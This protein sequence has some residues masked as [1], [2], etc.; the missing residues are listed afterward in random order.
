MYYNGDSAV[1]MD[2]LLTGIESGLHV[3]QKTSFSHDGS[4]PNLGLLLSSKIMIVDDEELNIEVV[5]EYLKIDGYENLVSTNDAR[6]AV[7]A[8]YHEKPDLVLLDLN[9][10]QVSG[11]DI[12][13]ELRS[14]QQLSGMPVIVLTANTD[15]ETKIRALKL[16]ATDFLYKP[17]HDGELLARLRNI[18]MAKAHQ[19]HMRNY[20]DQ[21]ETAVSQRTAE[22]EASRQEVIHCLARAAEFRDDDTGFHVIR[23]G[24]YARLIGEQLGMSE[25]RLD[26]LEQAA[27]LHD[28]GKIGIP[29]AILLKPGSLT[30]EEYE[31]MQ[32]HC[33]YGKKIIGKKSQ[34]ETVLLKTHTELGAKILEVGCSPILELATKIAITHHEHWD[35]SG[36]PLGLAG[37]DIPLEGRITAVA[38]VFDA[39][40]SKRPYKQAF[41]LEK[42]FSIMR[43]GQGSQF[44][45]QILDAFFAQQKR[46]VEVQIEYVD[47]E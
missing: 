5:K 32:R 17:I 13:Q 16:G 12:L 40:S 24:R 6:Q 39:L 45:P 27:K 18:L 8:I 35:G 43:E 14:D 44:D 7:A 29:D 22:L 25:Q 15:C 47:N 23:V 41:P 38:D 33:N 21:L 2:D 31:V 11:L 19:D 10:P 30:P 46:V 37:E 28:I 34:D 42:C 20:S 36:Y 4:D 3:Q 9:M 1:A 26:D